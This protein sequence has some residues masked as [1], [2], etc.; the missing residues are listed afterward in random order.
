MKN[1]GWVALVIVIVGG[2]IWFGVSYNN[3][4]SINVKTTMANLIIKD[5]AVGTGAEA[6]NGDLVT[7]N[8]VGTLDDGTKFDSSY[9][10]NKAFSFPLGVGQ[11]IKGWDL[12]VLGMKIGGKRDLTIPP[13]LGYRA[14]GIG[15]IPP[16]ATLHF[17]VELLSVQKAP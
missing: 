6:Q 15:S 16:N 5:V 7:V 17:T 3:G 13:E 10:R 9:D 12:G 1:W 4:S 2:L 14:S 11:V 8:Y